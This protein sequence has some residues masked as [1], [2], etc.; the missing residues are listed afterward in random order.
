MSKLPAPNRLPSPSTCHAPPCRRSETLQQSGA[1]P[2]PAKNSTTGL[3]P[4]ALATLS[5][6]R[7]SSRTQTTDEVEVGPAELRS[8]TRKEGALCKDV[9]IFAKPVHVAKLHLA[10]R[11]TMCAMWNFN[12]EL[13]P[14][15]GVLWGEWGRHRNKSH[16][17]RYSNNRSTRNQRR[18]ADRTLMDS[19]LHLQ[20][21][22]I[23]L[24]CMAPGQCEENE[25]RQCGKNKGL[26]R[27]TLGHHWDSR[28]LSRIR[29]PLSFRTA[30]EQVCPHSFWENESCE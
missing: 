6:F 30:Q 13:C 17:R 3:K 18:A 16:V 22:D 5:W 25:K 9:F 10:L 20:L 12:C 24:H 8:N 1:P 21:E 23:E 2:S 15:C 4:R 7:A 19:H 28:T 27:P 14:A 29:V 26:P 11:T